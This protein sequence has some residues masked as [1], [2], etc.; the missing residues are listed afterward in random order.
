MDE[1]ETG[2]L[3]GT[4]RGEILKVQSVA[5]RRLRAQI[6]YPLQKAPVFREYGADMVA[7]MGPPK[8]AL[9]TKYEDALARR[10]RKR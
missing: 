3:L 6:V 10:R 2:Q 7:L 4:P 5:Y 8:P 1:L 9:M